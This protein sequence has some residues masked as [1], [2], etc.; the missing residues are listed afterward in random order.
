MPPSR[1]SLPP[2]P[3]VPTA[4]KLETGKAEPD[5]DTQ[6]QAAIDA[7]I[8]RRLADL[9]LDDADARAD[10]ADLRAGLASL[11]KLRF[12]LIQKCVGW[13]VQAALMLMGLGILV[14]LSHQQ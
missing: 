10:L 14:I 7:V 4:D 5:H 1:S 8:T 11:R 2:S 9:G 13:F 6:M 12:G 3:L